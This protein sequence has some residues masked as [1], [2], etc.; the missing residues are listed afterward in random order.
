MPFSN[1]VVSNNNIDYKKSDTLQ[2]NNAKKISQVYTI[3]ESNDCAAM[4]ESDRG[5]ISRLLDEVISS[6]ESQEYDDSVAWNAYGYLYF[7]ENDYINAL[8]AYKN[9]VNNPNVTYTLRN[10]ALKTLA[11]LNLAIEPINVLTAEYYMNIYF[12]SSPILNPEDYAL[13]SQLYFWKNESILCSK[14]ICDY[15][16]IEKSYKSI[17]NAIAFAELKSVPLKENWVNLFDYLAEIYFKEECTYEGQQDPSSIKSCIETKKEE[18]ILM[19]KAR[20]IKS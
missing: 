9:V 8:K 4:S 3:L 12:D 10:P 14:E 1:F 2:P 6:T 18:D 7:C 19:L 17:V 20:K 16:S 15:D 13:K 11:Q 5:N